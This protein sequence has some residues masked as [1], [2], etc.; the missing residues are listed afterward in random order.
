LVFAAARVFADVRY[1]GA[2]LAGMG[3]AVGATKGALHFLF[4]TKADLARAVQELACS[5]SRAALADAGR[6]TSIQQT[7]LDPTL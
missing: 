7:L 2:T 3:Q 4:A 6:E 1:A 5:L